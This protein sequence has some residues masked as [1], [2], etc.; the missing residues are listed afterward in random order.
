[1]GPRLTG[2]GRGKG[3]SMAKY[4][5]WGSMGTA[6]LL[7]VLFLA[8]MIIGKPFSG[9]SITVDV[10]GALASGI[11]GYVSWEASRDLH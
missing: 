1:M 10:L 4:L 3:R 8:D 11:V 9:L 2:W 6:G 5:C 7:L